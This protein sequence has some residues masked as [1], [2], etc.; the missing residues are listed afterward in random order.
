LFLQLHRER[1]ERDVKPIGLREPKYSPFG[2]SLVGDAEKDLKEAR[3]RDEP[4][5]PSSLL[6]GDAAS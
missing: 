3:R 6:P 1:P 2:P 4:K 5:T